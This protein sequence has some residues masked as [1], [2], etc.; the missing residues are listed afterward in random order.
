MAAGQVNGRL[1]RRV[2]PLRL[3]TAG[4]VASTVG[5]LVLLAVVASGDLGASLGLAGFLVPLFCRGRADRLHHAERHGAGAVRLAE[6]GWQRIGAAGAVAVRARG[7]VAPLVG[8]GGSGTAL[9][10]ALAMALLEAAA[11]LALLVLGR[12]VGLVDAGPARLGP[13]PSPASEPTRVRELMIPTP[14]RGARCADLTRQQR[15]VAPDRSRRSH[16]RW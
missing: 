13:G 12:G 5:G 14:S 1:V 8:L 6:D 3:L 9:P 10:M 11:L 15:A 7:A 2:E 16:D 4:L